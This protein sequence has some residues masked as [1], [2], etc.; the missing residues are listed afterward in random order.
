MKKKY[1]SSILEK[2]IQKFFECGWLLQVIKGE[3]CLRN[4]NASNLLY[5]KV[6]HFEDR[7]D[8]PFEYGTREERNS[9][10]RI[11]QFIE[12]Y[13]DIINEYKKVYPDRIIYIN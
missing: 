1:K 10:L 6:G 5:S 8:T 11:L 9:A 13:P 12:D 3:Y 4:P 2:E 7:V